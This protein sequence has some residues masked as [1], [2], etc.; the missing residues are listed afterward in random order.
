[1]N[2]SDRIECAANFALAHVD[3]AN[4]KWLTCVLLVSMVREAVAR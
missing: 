2:G 1:M 3:C 4:K